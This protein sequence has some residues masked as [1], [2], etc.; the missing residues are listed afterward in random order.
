MKLGS[1]TRTLRLRSQ[2][3]PRRHRLRP[4]RVRQG[5]VHLALQHPL[6]IARALACVWFTSQGRRRGAMW[7]DPGRASIG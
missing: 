7:G 5:I 2:Q 6:A 4:P 1:H 3:P